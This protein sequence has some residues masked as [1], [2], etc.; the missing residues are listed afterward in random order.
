MPGV[1][2]ELLVVPNCPNAAPAAA[3][4][5]TAL[6]DVGLAHVP[7]TTTVIDTASQAERRGFIGS[8][9]I[10]IDGDDPFAEPRQPSALACRIYGTTTGPAGIP[11]LRQLR[12]A[13]KRAAAAHLQESGA[14]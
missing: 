14:V 4:L 11:D 6:A 1:D 3:L 2:V 8:P 9:T 10:L 7:I 12:Q 13:L 5:G